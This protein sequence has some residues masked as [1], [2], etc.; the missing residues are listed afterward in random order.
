MCSFASN[1][2]V[3]AWSEKSVVQLCLSYQGYR[4][5][6]SQPQTYLEA[7]LVLKCSKMLENRSKLAC[8]QCFFSQFKASN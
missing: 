3:S 8:E 5:V 7:I 6:Q 1:I 2:L 4:S